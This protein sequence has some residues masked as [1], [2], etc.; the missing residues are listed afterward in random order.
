MGKFLYRIFFRAVRWFAPVLVN[1]TFGSPSGVKGIG[2]EITC[3]RVIKIENGRR[4]EARW[5][6]T[7]SPWST[8]SESTP[9]ATKEEM[10]RTWSGWFYFDIDRKGLI[11]RHV[12][13]N[14]NN[15]REIETKNN[16]K[17]ILDRNIPKGQALGQGF[18]NVD[19]KVENRSQ[20]GRHPSTPRWMGY[21]PQA[22]PVSSPSNNVISA[23]TY[24]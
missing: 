3:F 7:S 9:Q 8:K 20:V 13:E 22:F 19:V 1:R 16:L 4:I 17:T 6:T 11:V 14:V 5:R 15:H 10:S 2:L 18:A 24:C 12:V 21:V 23:R